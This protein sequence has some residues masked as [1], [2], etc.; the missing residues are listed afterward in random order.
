MQEEQ[1]HA[2]KSGTN[3]TAYPREQYLHWWLCR[4]YAPHSE[5]TD[6]YHTRVSGRSMCHWNL[7]LVERAHR[8]SQVESGVQWHLALASKTMCAQAYIRIWEAKIGRISE[9]SSSEWLNVK[10]FCPIIWDP[11]TE[12]ISNRQQFLANRSGLVWHLC[13]TIKWASIR[14]RQITG[15]IRTDMSCRK[16]IYCNKCKQQ[17]ILLYQTQRRE[18]NYARALSGR[19]YFDS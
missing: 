2:A 16:N 7:Q 3:S 9:Y 12:L 17:S 5:I 8:A 1:F 14:F 6:E 18:W 11:E 15:A 13:N 10:Y 4:S 19:A